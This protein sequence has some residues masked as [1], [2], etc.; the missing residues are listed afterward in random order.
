M[1]ELLNH[2]QKSER[3][4]LT[5]HRDA[6]GDG[7]GSQIALYHALKKIGKNVSIHNVDP[8]PKKYEKLIDKNLLSIYQENQQ[9]PLFDLALVFDTNDQRLIEPLFS[10]LTVQGCQ[11]FFID[12]HPILKQGPKPKNFF[13][14]MKAASTGEIVFKLIDALKIPLD[15]PIANAL[16]TSLVFDTQLFR[17]TRASSFSHEMAL[18]LFPYLFRPEDIHRHLFGVQTPEKM[19]LLSRALGRVKYYLENKIAI[20]HLK[21]QD[22]EELHL[23]TEDTRD[24]VDKIID[25]DGV[26]VAVLF[27]EDKNQSFKVSFRSKNNINVLG[28]SELLGGGGHHHA[29]GAYIKG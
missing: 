10:N 17:Y 12:H 20:I 28:V 14:D 9:L 1:Q 18:K 5:T 6:D 4:L 21:H 27:R 11:I 16:Y 22:L 13:I 24:V 25:I 8:M 23:D 3:I 29:S 19:E 2:I 15:T 26:E 7:L